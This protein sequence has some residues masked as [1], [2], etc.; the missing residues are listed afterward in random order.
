M[1]RLYSKIIGMPVFVQ[2]S[3]RPLYSVQDLIIDPANGKVVALLVDSRK[4]LVVA[5]IDIIAIKHGVLVRSAE[6]IVKSDEILRVAAVIRDFGSL[7]GKKVFTENGKAIGKVVDIAVSDLA[8]VVSKIITA[9][10]LL[11]VV[12]YDGRIIPTSEIIEMK[13]DK[14]IVRDDVIT[15]RAKE[16]TSVKEIG[17][18]MAFSG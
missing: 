9:K 12:Q 13:K 7:H 10:S 4:R 3:P 5:S 18:E 8:L 6:D 1:D 14:V 17:A 11:G 15:V 2:D 16:K